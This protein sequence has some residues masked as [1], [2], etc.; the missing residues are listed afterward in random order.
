M[1]SNDLVKLQKWIGV[2][3]RL[4]DYFQPLNVGFSK[5]SQS[6]KQLDFVFK[7]KNRYSEAMDGIFLHWF[8]LRNKL[9]GSRVSIAQHLKTNA[10]RVGLSQDEKILL[11]KMLESSWSFYQVSEI[12][13][14]ACTYTLTEL[15]TKAEYKM[16]GKNAVSVYSDGCVVYTIPIE[17]EGIAFSI[18]SLPAAFKASVVE[19]I[20]YFLKDSLPK[21]NIDENFEVKSRKI[22]LELF[23][24]GGALSIGKEKSNISYLYTIE[25]AVEW[26]RKDF[27]KELGILNNE[28]ALNIASEVMTEKIINGPSYM[29]MGQTLKSLSKYPQHHSLVMEFVESL[30]SS[31]LM[32]EHRQHFS[33]KF[34]EKTLGFNN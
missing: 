29:I 18:G 31:D 27:P 16:I 13:K 12:N 8:G 30:C 23:R 25:K 4:L 10:N 22:A 34:R 26:M 32:G 24:F 11:D 14:S 15:W 6:S 21:K 5:Q 17:I 1:S 3:T 20:K 9:P 7:E 19:S 28:Q 2:H 33:A